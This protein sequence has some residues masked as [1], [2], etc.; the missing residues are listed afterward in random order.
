MLSI[1]NEFVQDA[2]D[3]ANCF[4]QIERES[5][6]QSLLGQRA[7]LMDEELVDF[8]WDE[9]HGGGSEDEG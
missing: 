2:G 8:A 3:Q 7:D 6:G 1:A 4:S 5:A 9:V